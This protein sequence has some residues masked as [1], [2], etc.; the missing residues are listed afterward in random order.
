MTAAEDVHELLD[1]L[2]E[3]GVEVWIDGGWGVDALVGE[4]TRE[5]DDLDVVVR[6]E[7]VDVAVAALAGLG[8]R[9]SEDWLPVRCKLVDGR[10]RGVDFHPVIFEPSGDAWQAAQDGGRFAFPR[11]GFAGRGT[12]GGRL[13]R[14]LAAAVQLLHHKGYEPTDTDLHDVALLRDRCAAS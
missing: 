6:S 2:A 13:V 9:I 12:I 3:A 4:Q 10:G 1:A 14:C 11:E 8:F 5:H 7:Q